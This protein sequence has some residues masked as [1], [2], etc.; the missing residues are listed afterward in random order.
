MREENKGKKTD[1]QPT[2]RMFSSTYSKNVLKQLIKAR[3][4]PER[5]KDLLPVHNRIYNLLQSIQ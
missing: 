1:I 2:V 4:I 5:L 3:M